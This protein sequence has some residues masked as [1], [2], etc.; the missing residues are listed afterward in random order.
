VGVK[1][2]KRK[3]V[4]EEGGLFNTIE[5]L[6][7]WLARRIA[8]LPIAQTP[9]TSINTQLRQAG[10]YLGL[11]AD[12][13]LALC[14]LSALGCS[15]R[16]CSSTQLSQHRRHLPADVPRLRHDPAAHAGVGRDR[17]ALQAGQPRPA[18]LHRPRGPHH[19]RG[20][21]LPR[22]AAAGHREDRRQA[23]TPSTK[24]CCASSRSWSSG[25]PASRRCWPSVRPLPHGGR[26]ATS[27]RRWCRPRRRATPS[28]RCS[29]FKPPCSACGA[30]S[31]R[32]R[33]RPARAC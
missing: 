18:P 23:P 6:M 25:A 28:P 17:A 2:L 16:A 24:S 27:C 5:P 13:Y 21:G 10:E 32:R 19:E 14:V 9:A 33:A 12:E 15:A 1:G 22:R 26:D 11:T 8:S 4:L 3:A 30:A 20:P 31:R 29:R 7:R